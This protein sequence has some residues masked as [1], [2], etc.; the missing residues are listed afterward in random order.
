M[1]RKWIYPV[2]LTGLF[3]LL[4]RLSLPA[5]CVYGST[6]DW[7]SQHTALAETIRTAMLEQKTLLPTYLSLGGGSN[8]FQFSYY[9]YL[10]PDILLGCLLPA[11]SMYKIVIAYALGGYLLS[12][13]LFYLL[14]RR[15]NLSGFDSFMGSVLFL[16][17]SCFF[18]THRQLMFVNYM[19]FL[20]L[21]LLAVKKSPRRMPALLPLWMLLICLHSFYYAPACFVVIGWYWAWLSGKYF[22][23]P[24]FVSCALGGFMAFA[25]L[26]PTGLSILEHRR[27]STSGDAGLA[28]FFEDFQSLLYSSYGLGVTLI[29]LYL[30]ILGVAIRKYRAISL[31]FLLLFLWGGISYLLN[32]TLYARAKILMPFLPLLLL[33]CAL[34]LSDLKNGRE[35]W[36]LWPFPLLFA[37]I[38]RYLNK[39]YWTLVLTDFIFL[40]AVVLL[41]MAVSEERAEAFEGVTPMPGSRLRYL[42]SRFAFLCLLIMPCLFFLRSAS[43]E[44]FVTQADMD[45]ALDKPALALYTDSLYRYDSLVHPL[46][47][48]NREA[49]S[50]RSKSSMYSSVYSNEY[51]QVYYDYLKTP[52]QINNRLA[53]LTA[54]N[55]F[56]LNFMGVRYLETSPSHV[57]AGYRVLWEDGKTAVSENTSVLPTAYLT[58]DTMT[59][60]LFNRIKG[61][62]QAEALTRTTVIPESEAD[63]STISGKVSTENADGWHTEIRYYQPLW[64]SKEIPATVQFTTTGDIKNRSYDLKVSRDSTVT[65]TFK[66]PIQEQLLLLKF[67]VVNHTGKAVTITI[68]GVK[69]KLSAPS[70]AYPNGNEAFQYQF[71]ASAEK[72]LTK[73]KIKLPKGHYT[74]R[75]IRFGLLDA[76]VFQEK[77]WNSVESLDTEKNEILAC[78]A[79]TDEDTWFVTSIP[80]QKG[81]TLFVDGEKT[82]LVT[83][84]TAFAG[85][86]LTAGEHEIRLCFDP[87][88]MKA[89]IWISMLAGIVWLSLLIFQHFHANKERH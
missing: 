69:N 47:N 34:I 75:N 12:V 29:V 68:N 14:L 13:L 28:T 27:A 57:P 9:G 31:T 73:L 11:V 21:A 37:V 54:N 63:A 50:V 51:S 79:S 26:L 52:V 61:W 45:A 87:P 49:S 83:V 88:G 62:E 42:L 48:G 60:T 82:D 38:F 85:A 10:R 86:R 56:L 7:L 77:S 33:H 32:A 2:L 24:W 43:K 53:I 44:E 6:T 18:H 30:V 39:S 66:Q 25:L 65:L 71:L 22:F 15:H 84:N 55:P 64:S 35:R 17:A 36:Q 16:T 67:D 19:P 4:I 80:M 78:R 23:R 40:L 3:A 1:T 72:E 74:L 20:L 59:D 70:A 41:A 46:V 89:G 5:G 76:S 81:M 8:G 58:T